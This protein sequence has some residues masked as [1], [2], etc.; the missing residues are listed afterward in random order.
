MHLCSSK[1][2]FHVSGSS[3]LL[4]V[5]GRSKLFAKII[6]RHQKTTIFHCGPRPDC[7]TWH[8]GAYSDHPSFCIQVNIK[9]YIHRHFQLHFQ[10]AVQI[11]MD[12]VQILMNRCAVTHKVSHSILKICIKWASTRENLSLGVCEE[13]R[14]RPACAYAQSDQRLCYPLIGKYHI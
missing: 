5:L 9:G 7:P 12:K 2:P 11:L 13:H 8:G 4:P 6:T 10:L 3:S 14:R 1:K